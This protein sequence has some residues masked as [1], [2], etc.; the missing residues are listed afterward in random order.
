MDKYLMQTSVNMLIYMNMGTNTFL[1][2]NI[3]FN[4]LIFVYCINSK[5][6]AL[7]MVVTPYIN[8]TF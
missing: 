1:L 4:L 3:L 5:N 6:L 8:F 2:F 7:A